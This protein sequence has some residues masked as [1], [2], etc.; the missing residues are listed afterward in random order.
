MRVSGF[1]LIRNGIKFDYPF[2]ESI[3]SVLPLV[4]EFVLNV[5]QGDDATLEKVKSLATLF[6]SN[7]INIFAARFHHLDQL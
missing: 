5:G 1:S 2:L 6:G 4:D 3:R 7:K